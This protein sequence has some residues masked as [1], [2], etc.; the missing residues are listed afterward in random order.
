MKE[1]SIVAQIKALG[2]DRVAVEKFCGQHQVEFHPIGCDIV[3]DANKEG[4]K[5][6]HVSQSQRAER[7][8]SFAKA[9]KSA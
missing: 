5:C 4:T 9:T 7:E 1:K 8:A 2:K 6:Q 3:S